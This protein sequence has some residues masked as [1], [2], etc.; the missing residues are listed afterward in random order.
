M[1]RTARYSNVA[2]ALHWLIAALILGLF[3]SGL[4]MTQ[5]ILDPAQ[6]LAA[7]QTYQTHKAIGVR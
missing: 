2:I 5:A 6:R 3:V 7:F 4:W 1:P